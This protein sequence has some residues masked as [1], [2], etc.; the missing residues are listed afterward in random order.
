MSYQTKTDLHPVEVADK[1]IYDL[2]YAKGSM[3]RNNIVNC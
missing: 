3:N 1:M 2:S